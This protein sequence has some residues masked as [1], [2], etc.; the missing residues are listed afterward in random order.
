MHYIQG[1]TKSI[2][3]FVNPWWWVTKSIF[4]CRVRAH[5][6]FELI[7]IFHLPITW[8]DLFC[9]SLTAIIKVP[10]LHKK[11]QNGP[12]P[13]AFP[14]KKKFRCHLLK[15]HKKKHLIFYFGVDW[16]HYYLFFTKKFK[17]LTSIKWRGYVYAAYIFLRE[18]I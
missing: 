14:L 10:N 8:F 16:T 2:M 11:V 1:E 9:F 17:V 7:F 5:S 6:N 15:R 12:D 18:L 3:K 4:V 13:F